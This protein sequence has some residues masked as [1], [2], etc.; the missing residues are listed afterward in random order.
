MA[1]AAGKSSTA[2][3]LLTRFDRINIMPLTANNC[4]P[5]PP[6]SA[7]VKPRDQIIDRPGSLKAV[8]HHEQRSEEKQQFPVHPLIH[9]LAFTRPITRMKAP[10]EIATMGNE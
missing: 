5:K 2:G 3:T 10:T 4:L 1:P 8:D 6:S 9:V 7:L